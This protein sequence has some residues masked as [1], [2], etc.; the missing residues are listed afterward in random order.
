[1]KNETS[2]NEQPCTL[3][4]VSG[5]TLKTTTTRK[6]S[7]YEFACEGCG[8]LEEMSGYCVAQLASGNDIVFTCECGHKTDL[9]AF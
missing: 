4:S 9:K 2:K 7:K 1:M 6:L 5:S 3:H 8:K